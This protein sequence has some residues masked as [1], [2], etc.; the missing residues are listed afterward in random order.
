MT[1][2]GT[3][4]DFGPGSDEALPSRLQVCGNKG[5]P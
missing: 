4:T 2:S 1:I 5:Q 3:G